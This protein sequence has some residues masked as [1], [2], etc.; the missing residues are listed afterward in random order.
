MKKILLPLSLIILTGVV[1]LLLEDT[2]I[3]Q[4]PPPSIGDGYLLK[5]SQEETCQACH[6]TDQNTA[7]PG[8]AGYVQAEWDN[9]IKTHSAEHLGACSNTTYKTKTACEANGGTWTP[10]KW[11]AS[12]GWGV[13]GGKYGLFSCTTCHTAHGTKNIYL[14]KETITTPDG[15]NFDGR[16]TNSA[17]VDFRVKSGTPGVT[18]GVMGDDTGGHA[19]STRV[20]EACHSQT[21]YHKYNQPAD[22]G[23]ENANDCTGCHTHKIAFTG[24][25]TC[26]S[27]HGAP[28]GSGDDNNLPAPYTTMHTNKHYDPAAGGVPTSYTASATRSTQTAYVFDC[29]RCHSTNSADHG[30]GEND[31]IVNV[32][33]KAGET[34]AR[35]STATANTPPP[36]SKTFY[37]Y[38]STCSS[39]YC[40]GNFAGSG[41]TGNVPT[42]GNAA[43]GAC[44]TCHGASAA[45]PPS[46]GSH[47]RHA[48][49]AA[50]QLS[51]SCDTCHEG[52]VDS[53]P[54][55]I[56]K[57]KHVNEATDWDLKRTD[58]RI[59]ASSVYNGAESG[60]KSP[61]S[62]TYATCSTVYCHSN[63]QGA[64]GSGAPTSYGT[65]TWGAAG[66]LTCSTASC[67]DPM[68]SGTGTGSHTKHA[69]TYSLACS[70]CHNNA[71][72]E[73]ALHANYSIDMSFSGTGAGTAY[74][75]SPNTPGGGYGTCSTSYC[76]SSGQSA[77]GGSPPAYATPT[78][79]G[80]ANCG[81][82]HKDMDTD[83]TAPGSHVQH[84]QGSVN[85]GC[86][87]C[88]N[89]YTES[90]VATATHV[91]NL[92]NLSFSGTGAGTTYSQGASHAVGNNYGNCTTSNCH[93][94]RAG[95]SS[96]NW[97]TNTTNH[98]C[99]KCHGNPTAPGSYVLYKAAPGADT[100]G[101]DLEGQTG[102]VTSN[103]SNDAQVGAHDVHLRALNQYSNPI[104]CSECHAV[105]AAFDSPGHLDASPADITWGDLA[106]HNSAVYSGGQNLTPNYAG[107]GGSCTAVY[108]HGGGTF[109]ADASPGTKTTPTWTA[110]IL[111]GTGGGDCGKCHGNPPNTGGH[112]GV[113]A[114]VCSSCHS[115]VNDSA[116]AAPFFNNLAL[117]INGVLDGGISNGGQLCYSCHGS[118]QTAM[119]DGTGKVG[120]TRTTYYHHVL[121]GALGDGEIAPNAGNY[122]T[123]TTDVYCVSCHVDHNY[124]NIALGGTKSNNLRTNIATASPQTTQ[125]T[126]FIVGG[127]PTYG[128][129]ITCHSSSLAKDTTNQKSDGTTATPAIVGA[130]YDTSS[131]DYTVTSTFSGSAT[132]FNA[133]CSKCHNDEQTKDKQTSTNK[134][135]THYSAYR[136]IL[137][138]LG[139][140]AP[141]DPLEEN[142]CYRCHSRSTETGNLANPGG[143]PAKTT[144]NMDYYGSRA[145]GTNSQLI[146]RDLNTVIG[147]V[148]SGSSTT[149]VNVSGTTGWTA[150]Q[151][152][153]YSFEITSG[154]LAGQSRRITANTA[155]SVTVTAAFASN[156]LAGVTYRIGAGHNMALANGLHKPIE[157]TA[158]NW[159]PSASR[160]VEC[161]DCHSPH[162]ARKTTSYTTGTAS[163]GTITTL[164]GS[165]GT[166]WPTD[167]WKNYRIAI[168]GGTGT[169]QERYIASNTSNVITI[170]GSWSTAPD[171][172]SQYKIYSSAYEDGGVATGGT[173]TTL[174]DTSRAWTANQWV[175]YYVQTVSGTGAGQLR[176]ITA[177]TATSLTVATWT[178][179]AAGTGYYIYKPPMIAGVNSGIANVVTA[180]LDTQKVGIGIPADNTNMRNTSY[181]AKAGAATAQ[182]ELCLK[183]HSTWA[184]NAEPS[185]INTPSKY[186]S[187]LDNW[188]STQVQTD[189]GKDFDPDNYA[190]HALFA[191]GKN[192]P[193][194]MGNAQ[195]AALGQSIAF[196]T[197]WPYVATGTASTGG[198]AGGTV[199]VTNG[200]T[201]VT[202]TGT[203]FPVGAGAGWWIW[204]NTAGTG[205]GTPSNPTTSGIGGGGRGWWPVASRNSATSLTLAVPF[206]GTTGSG[207]SFYLTKG[208]KTNFVDGWGP[209]SLT[210]C[211]DCHN[212]SDNSG[213]VTVA[214]ARGPHG[215]ASRWL[216]RNQEVQTWTALN[217]TVYT[218][219]IDNPMNFCLNCHSKFTY[220]DNEMTNGEQITTSPTPDNSTSSRIDHDSFNNGCFGIGISGNG[221]YYNIPCMNC[222]GG[223]GTVTNATTV[224]PGPGT[225]HG[226][227][228]GVGFQG[229]SPRG[230]RFMN[231]A[232]WTGHTTAYSG[233]QT[234]YTTNGT[235]LSSCTEHT[236]G[237]TQSAL[238]SY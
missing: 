105:P 91:N 20:C 167:Q 190:H 94:T 162:A 230:F 79:G 197:N 150:N 168:T 141:T 44:G 195:A 42:W 130:E 177:N 161:E 29:G 233:N 211:T 109:P 51:L 27:C 83:G 103:V 55:I 110:S 47:G 204:I 159:M 206:S 22:P 6:K 61:P 208:L 126:D 41:N 70:T 101:R 148:A 194:R 174:A 113:S 75:Q 35:G 81:N 71:G 17:A 149:V 186:P 111:A 228:Q 227:N 154:A 53:T 216:L 21:G 121:G 8:Q 62:T 187:A 207:S 10:G 172:T 69:Q 30:T 166:N 182:Y 117:H 127:S 170:K 234:C 3:S 160:H 147:T 1:L 236:G 235:S 45:N 23:H 108:C 76:H 90:T 86:G 226:S 192:Q 36:G 122:P 128:V 164:T 133:N 181:S 178:A 221:N 60:T 132:P 142:F 224:T 5:R 183:C 12:G 171:N 63:I 107:G 68:N 95:A 9:A 96:P 135:G 25:G 134:F 65:P 165:A 84:A 229:T 118:Y 157:G 231:G 203:T 119:E 173:T 73:S 102:T 198:T 191:P 80:T 38:D 188:G 205:T 52:T 114:N 104:A 123:S 217:G 143:G 238:Y 112:G 97:G 54:A 46:G 124:F 176:L 212:T 32:N 2:G 219:T 137:A 66:P 223:T 116:V 222:H 87:V 50:G 13:A 89:G 210:T 18:V 56:S 28:P 131:H 139:I 200:S 209:E 232:S 74:S 37:N 201:A 144:A 24:G 40:H 189:I 88:H 49:S 202:G 215:S 48:G 57:I 82:C 138:T 129:C 220:L 214:K 180:G 100:T 199:S 225:I 19:T 175:G 156:P 85:Y 185:G 155:T 213:T 72:D 14:I 58:N 218:T 120:A 77:T 98:Q 16:A 78:W 169:G 152:V 39:V 33:L 34:F 93:G 92:I 153:G 26:N 115:H 136:R 158:V 99:T 125:T 31:G 145:M 237:R 146:W 163:A 64:G 43:S 67:H 11:A 140:T 59:G 196:N 15:T 151:W 184:Y 193:L 179:P 4:P 106:K 7:S